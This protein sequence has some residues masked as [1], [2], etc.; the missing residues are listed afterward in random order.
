MK[1]LTRIIFALTLVVFAAQPMFACINCLP[2]G[3]CGQGG[4]GVKCKPLTSSDCTDGRPCAAFT[5]SLASEYRI[6]SVEITQGAETRIAENKTAKPATSRV[7][8]A[9]K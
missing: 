8:E 2:T 1:R 6:A 9:H 7:A 4:T 5:A 3:L